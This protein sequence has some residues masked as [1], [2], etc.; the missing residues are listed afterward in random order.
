[1]TESARERLAFLVRALLVF[2]GVAPFVPALTRGV[3]LLGAFGQGLDAWFSFHCHRDPARSLAGCAVC[4][5]CL[6]IYAGLALG[7]LFGR[8]HLGSKHLHWLLGA[9]LVLVLDVA[10]EG[11][12]LRPPSG[13]LRFATGFAFAYAAGVAIVRALKARTRS[14]ATAP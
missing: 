12:S 9:A 3:P 8:P 14:R 10:S 2:F 4:L 5:R 6:G 11:L 13:A 1:M 7:A